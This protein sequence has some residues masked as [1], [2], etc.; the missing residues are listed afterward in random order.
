MAWSSGRGARKLLGPFPVTG[1]PAKGQ[2]INYFFPPPLG[3]YIELI[4]YPH[5]MAYERHA[6]PPLWSPRK[7]NS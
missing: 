7:P 4:S 5:G 1:G 3:R 6:N 2:T